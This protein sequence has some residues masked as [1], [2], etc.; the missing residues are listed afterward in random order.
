MKTKFQD[1]EVAINERKKKIFYQL[2]RR[3]KNYSSKQ[4]EYED[5]WIED[6]EETD[7]TTQFR[8]ISSLIWNNIWR[9]M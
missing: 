4:F 3:S 5:D 7:M 9:D 2:N 6:S 8:K 1:I